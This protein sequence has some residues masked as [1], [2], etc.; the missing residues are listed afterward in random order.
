MT[1]FKSCPMAGMT[2]VDRVLNTI[3]IIITVMQVLLSFIYYFGELKYF[4]LLVPRLFSL[5]CF[6]SP[7]CRCTKTSWWWVMLQCVQCC[8]SSPWSLTRPWLA[9]SL[10][11]TRSCTRSSPREHLSHTK[12]S[13]PGYWYLFIRYVRTVNEFILYFFF[14]E[15]LF[16]DYVAPLQRTGKV[17]R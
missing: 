8:Q 9:R 10:S 1:F 6:T 16:V 7:R 11:P 12:H 13:S 5:P 4:H 14:N 17:K 3:I 15:F 2:T